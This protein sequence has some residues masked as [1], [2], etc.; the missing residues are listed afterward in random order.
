MEKLFNNYANITMPTKHSYTKVNKHTQMDAQ[1][2]QFNYLK[3][4]KMSE[5]LIYRMKAQISLNQKLC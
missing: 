4:G 2:Y 3:I 1:D 5:K